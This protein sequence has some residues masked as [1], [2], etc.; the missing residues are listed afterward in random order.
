MKLA[1][2]SYDKDLNAALDPSSGRCALF[3][4][5]DPEDM[6]FGVFENESGD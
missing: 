2:S 4:V 1:I 5:V 6:G 3:L